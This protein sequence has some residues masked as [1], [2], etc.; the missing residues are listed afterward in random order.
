MLLYVQDVLA[1]ILQHILLPLHQ[2]IS[3]NGHLCSLYYIYLI[4]I[5]TVNFTN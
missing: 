2:Y 4:A 3:I 1:V 5:T